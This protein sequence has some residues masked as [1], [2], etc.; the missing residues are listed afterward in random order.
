MATGGF[1]SFPCLAN[2]GSEG[3]H[4]A[5]RAGW[6]AADA[7][8]GWPDV[9]VTRHDKVPDSGI[10]LKGALE[11]SW[12]RVKDKQEG[13]E[14]WTQGGKGVGDE[15]E[16]GRGGGGVKGREGFDGCESFGFGVGRTE[17][18]SKVHV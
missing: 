14:R 1:S 12:G 2:L 7:R 18:R 8:L 17:S 15:W 4:G 6:H 5:A 16:G 13:E 11:G 10:L 9:L 3:V